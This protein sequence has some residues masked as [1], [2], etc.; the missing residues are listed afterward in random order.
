MSPNLA[1]SLDVLLAFMGLF[2]IVYVI[3]GRVKI[4]HS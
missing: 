4:D 3:Y 1:F 2:H